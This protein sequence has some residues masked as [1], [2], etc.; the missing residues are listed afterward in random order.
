MH[1]HRLLINYSIQIA[2]DGL[3]A[4]WVIWLHGVKVVGGNPEENDPELQAY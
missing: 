1:T 4:D 3:V 2:G